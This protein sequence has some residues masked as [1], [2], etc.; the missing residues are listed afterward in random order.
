MFTVIFPTMWKFEPFFE[1][2]EELAQHYLVGEIIVVDNNSSQRPAL[3]ILS[4]EKIRILDFGKNTYVNGAWN[5]GVLESKFDKLCFCNDDIIFDLRIFSKAL[6]HVTED[7]G[8]L[9]ISVAPWEQYITDGLIRIKNYEKGD[10]QWGFSLCFF[11]HKSRYEPVPENMKLF[12]GDNFVFDNCIWRNLPI[13]IIKDVWFYTP[14]G[15]TVKQ[16]PEK[17]L[18]DLNVNDALAYRE[19]ILSK[20]VLDPY[21]WSPSIKMIFEKFAPQFL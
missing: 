10:G 6:P 11:M 9:G 13:K 15:A 17:D 19:L 1:F 2:L 20:G 14:C 8:I 5:A 16:M 4:H 18:I 21:T 3:D 7:I 12:F